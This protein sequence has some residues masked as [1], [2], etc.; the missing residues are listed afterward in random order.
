MIKRNQIAALGG[1]IAIAGCSGGGGKVVTPATN[2]AQAVKRPLSIGHLTINPTLLH[3][4]SSKRRRPAFVD[5]QGNGSPLVL[6]IS[7]ITNDGTASSPALTTVSISSYSAPVNLS[8]PLYGPGGYL[9]IQEYSVPEGFPQ[10]LLADTDSNNDSAIFS[11][12]GFGNVRYSIPQGQ[13]AVISVSQ[14]SSSFSSAAVTLSA[15]IGGIAFDDTPDGSDFPRPLSASTGV[16]CASAF[17]GETLFLFPADASGNFTS[18]AVP[19][20][21]PFPVTFA[22]SDPS[23]TA[24]LVPTNVAGVYKFSGDGSII[25]AQFQTFDG[26]DNFLT[27]FITLDSTGYL[28]GEPG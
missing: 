28:C 5:A 13:D 24:T 7:S 18:S 21:F 19:G 10:Q 2:P 25:D 9:R 17:N 3:H 22:G 26:F 23:S 20:G 14:N 27:A 11:Q 16:A 12:S 6:Q 1:I 15:I 8:I 4:A